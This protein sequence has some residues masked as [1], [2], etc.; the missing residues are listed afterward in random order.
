M[1]GHHHLTGL[2][3]GHSARDERSFQGLWKLPAQ[4]TT[5]FAVLRW[6][7]TFHTVWND[8]LAMGIKCN[9]WSQH[10]SFSLEVYNPFEQNLTPNFSTKIQEVKP[11]PR[12]FQSNLWGLA[13]NVGQLQTLATPKCNRSKNAFSRVVEEPF[14]NVLYK[15]L[16]PVPLKAKSIWKCGKFLR[17]SGTVM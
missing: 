8:G 15:Y 7:W 13:A 5:G 6:K 16:V 11:P 9:D 2:H 4:L 17:A 10:A 14:S 12:C 3:W 1:S